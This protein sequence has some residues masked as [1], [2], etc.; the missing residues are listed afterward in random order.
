MLVRAAWDGE[1]DAGIWL[2]S[3]GCK[4]LL[5][6]SGV[7]ARRDEAVTTAP[8]AGCKA[9]AVPDARRRVWGRG[10]AGAGF[11]CAMPR[12]LLVMVRDGGAEGAR[13]GALW[14]IRLPFKTCD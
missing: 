4:R 14:E 9:G 2:G 7:V 13:S 6:L 12:A 8:R 10:D 3:P 1:D 5:L 11:R